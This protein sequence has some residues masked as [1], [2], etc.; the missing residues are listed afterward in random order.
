M[1]IIAVLIVLLTLSFVGIL[2]GSY[3]NLRSVR[4]GHG[5]SPTGLAI[6]V[7]ANVVVLLVVSVTFFV[8]IEKSGLW[9]ATILLIPILAF[10]VIL[11]IGAVQGLRGRRRP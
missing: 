5:P 10:G 7:A 4:S 3:V 1:S 11:V 6:Q 9:P 2:L 8:A